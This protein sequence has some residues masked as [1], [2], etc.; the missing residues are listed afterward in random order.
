[1]RDNITGAGRRAR[2][3]IAWRLL[4]FV[5]LM[6]IICYVDRANVSFANLRMSVELGFSDRVYGLGVGMFFIGYVLFEVPGAIVVERWSARKWLARIMITWGMA[7]I[8]TGFVHT[9]TQFYIAR[10]LVGV[11]EASFFPGIIVYLTHWFRQQDRAKAI[12]SFYAAVPAASVVGS[13]IATWL[14]GVHW[15]GLSGW[16]WI[17]VLEGIPPILVGIVTIFY[18]TDRPQQARWLAEDERDWIV[19]ELENEAVAKKRMREYTILQAF[20]DPRV[21]LLILA[22]F[23]AL[24]AALANT[25]WQPTFIKRLSGLPSTRVALLASLPGLLG[26]AAMLLNGWHSDR[27]G[28]RRWHTA[29]P[30]LCAGAAYMLLLTSTHNFSLT[31]LLFVLGG[32]LMF[33][34]YP[35]FWSMPTMLLT[36]SA[37]AACFGLINSIGQAGGFVGPYVVGYLNGKSGSLSSAFAFIGICYL[38]AA[39]IISAV[40]MKVP[41]LV[42]QPVLLQKALKPQAAH[43]D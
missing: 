35:V 21:L 11:A 37:A 10:L 19:S 15:R 43:R 20:R 40:R 16:Q 31:L 39:A 8:F 1:M 30:L 9:P 41:T 32:G 14:L 26:I 29:I 23:F 22:Y 3:R 5:F 24:T 25:Y 42:P 18:L 38:S 36:E 33:A 12:A 27:S 4:P 13:F 34:Y 2:P 7:T 17:F 6:Y 28:E